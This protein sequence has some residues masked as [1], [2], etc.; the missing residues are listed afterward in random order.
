[1]NDHDAIEQIDIA[2]QS[3]YVGIHDTTEV[4]NKIAYILGA[5]SFEHRKAKENAA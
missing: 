5:N 1:M 3:F 2:M 4:L